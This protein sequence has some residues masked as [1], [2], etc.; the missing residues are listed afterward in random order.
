MNLL[1]QDTK[2]IREVELDLL[3]SLLTQY[4]TEGYIWF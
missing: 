4:E 3:G 1:S 2:G